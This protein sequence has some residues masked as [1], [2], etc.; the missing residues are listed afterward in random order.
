MFKKNL[1]IIQRAY[2]W[3]TSLGIRTLIFKLLFSL[4]LLSASHM[5]TPFQCLAERPFPGE[6]VG[7]SQ[8]LPVEG[9]RLL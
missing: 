8:T 1:I 5:T 3:K 6:G 2:V 4:D 9:Q 7:V